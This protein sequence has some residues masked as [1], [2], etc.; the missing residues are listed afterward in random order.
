MGNNIRPS[1][2][3]QNSVLAGIDLLKRYKLH[4]T[5]TSVNAIR[6]FRDYRWKKDKANRLTNIPNDGSDHIPDA[7]R[8]ATYSLMSKPNYGKYAIR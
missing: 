5:E 4:V 2:K 6:E 7:V 1:V 3:G 8:Y